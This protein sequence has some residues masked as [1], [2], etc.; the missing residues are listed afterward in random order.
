MSQPGFGCPSC[1]RRFKWKPT[2][3]GRE[4]TCPCGAAIRV[5]VDVS[6]GPIPLAEP[7]P[8]HGGSRAAQAP[9]RQ[10]AK[11]V[12]CNAPLTGVICVRCG[13]DQ[14]TGKKLATQTGG[15]APEPAF[16]PRALGDVR[17]GDGDGTGR[18]A[19]RSKGMVALEF[20]LWCE[21]M[22][23]LL[24]VLS[25]IGI[26]VAMF[27]MD[28]D[29]ATLML[30]LLVIGGAVL[31]ILSY[32]LMLAV[33]GEAKARGVLIVALIMSVAEI[34]LSLIAEDGSLMSISA[35]FLGFLGT[36]MFLVFLKQLAEFFGFPEIEENA[37][38]VLG[39]FILLSIG[40][41]IFI[42]PGFGFFYLV[43]VV[44]YIGTAIY[45]FFLYV[46]L[47]IDLLNSTRYRRHHGGPADSMIR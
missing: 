35:G 4:T 45:A 39:F 10:G 31:S 21:L 32:F 28:A 38:K 23:I 25:V 12:N 13:T 19:Y 8:D 46:R 42:L 34:G 11:C 18:D 44:M 20:G 41:V 15:A 6:T 36:V 47:L 14:R 29:Q 7:L 40:Q 5:P 26:I 17:R 22:S 3:A 27:A 16:D 1:G 9:A 37:D 2:L 43:L 24:T 30:G 33:P